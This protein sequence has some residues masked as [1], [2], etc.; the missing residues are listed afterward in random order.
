MLPGC[1]KLGTEWGTPLPPIRPERSQAP[2]FAAARDG[3]DMLELASRGAEV[4]RAATTA[5][6]WGKKDFVG[7]LRWAGTAAATMA[8]RRQVKGRNV[9]LDSTGRD[10]PASAHGPGTEAMVFPKPDITAAAQPW[11]CSSALRFLQPHPLPRWVILQ[12]QALQRA[13]QWVPEA[14]G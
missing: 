11:P 8:G 4:L 3:S 6:G 9:S 7:Y 5:R 1:P 14:Q 12:A 13:A 2:A 10:C